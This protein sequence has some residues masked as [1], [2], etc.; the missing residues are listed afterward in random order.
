MD[1]EFVDSREGFSADEDWAD[2]E[3]HLDAMEESR[4]LAEANMELDYVGFAT[5]LF[6]GFVEILLADGELI[7]AGPIDEML[8]V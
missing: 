8:G 5:N 1:R 6:Q 7:D 4:R 3:R 2:F